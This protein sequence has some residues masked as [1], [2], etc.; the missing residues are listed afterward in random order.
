MSFCFVIDKLVLEDAELEFVQKYLESCRTC[1]KEFLNSLFN[2]KLERTVM[3]LSLG[4]EPRV[5][6]FAHSTF[7]TTKLEYSGSNLSEAHRA[8]ARINPEE[9][10]RGREVWKHLQAISEHALS[11]GEDG[12]FVFLSPYLVVPDED[13]RCTVEVCPSRVMHCSH[14]LMQ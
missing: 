4:N 3:I 12:W 11:F 13:L 5:L 10:L 8:L 7:L 9:P 14:E 2:W 1:L 6:S